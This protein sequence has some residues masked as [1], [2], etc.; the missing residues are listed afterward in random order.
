LRNI[1]YYVLV[2]GQGKKVTKKEQSFSFLD[3]QS[4]LIIS[5]CFFL[6]NPNPL[7]FFVTFF[8]NYTT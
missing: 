3:G 1:P 7:N 5:P 6:F 2:A 8:E 4:T